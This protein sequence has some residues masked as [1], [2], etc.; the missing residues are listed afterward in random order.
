MKDKKIE[1]E[2]PVFVKVPDEVKASGYCVYCREYYNDVP[3]VN[4]KPLCGCKRK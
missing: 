2:Q 1:E 4:G 3:V